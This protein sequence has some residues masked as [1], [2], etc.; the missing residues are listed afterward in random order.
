[1]TNGLNNTGGTLEA[2]NGGTLYFDG[3]TVNNTGANITA[4]AGSTVQF[5]GNTTIQ[6]G[7]LTNNGT[8]LGTPNGN[9]AILD[10]STGAGAITINGTY[11]N[12][13][14]STTYISG[15]DQ[16]QQQFPVECGRWR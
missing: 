10:G 6:G 4:N 13:V 12:G 3:V 11:T 1:M 2:S 5:V 15:D 16:Q 7:T 9:Q 8:F 14:G